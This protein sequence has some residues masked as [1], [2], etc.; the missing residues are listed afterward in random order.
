M[1]FTVTSNLIEGMLVGKTVVGIRE[2]YYTYGKQLNADDIKFLSKQ[3]VEGL[4][5]LESEPKQVITNSL[6]QECLNATRE[7][8][9]DAILRV[10]PK[11]AEEMISSENRLVDIR[12]ERTYD[13]YLQYHCFYTAVYAVMVGVKLGLEKSLIEKLSLCGLLHD[14]GITRVDREI[15]NKTEKLSNEE[16]D[17]IKE[18]TKLGVEI[19]ENDC[20]IST[21]V[22]ETVLHHHENVNGT[23][24]PGGL[25]DNNISILDKILRVADSYDALVAKRPYREPMSNAEAQ[26]YL[27]GGKKIL[28]DE[29][30]VDAFVSVVAPFPTGIE[31]NLSNGESGVVLQQTKDLWKPVVSIERKGIVDLSTSSE[32]T[33]VVINDSLPANMNLQELERAQENRLASK[34]KKK[35]L[36]VDD[37]FVSLVYTKALLENDFDVVISLGGKEAFTKIAVE[38]PDL[39]LLD[40]EMPEMNGVKMV[41]E[42]NN[43]GFY[44]PIIFLTGKSNSE[45][46][47]MCHKCG[48]VDY[49][50]K[51][52][53]AV[54]LKKRIEIALGELIELN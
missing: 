37:V 11:L 32:Y 51:P 53:N 10:A 42:M 26:L 3:G 24:Y 38:K 1:H 25:T 43:M 33:N 27:M 23:G 45:V 52:A 39:I 19:L 34:P 46:V 30:V 13:D 35:I 15:L 16:F 2:G 48:A 12:S 7:M 40:Y 17:C 36:I 14:I 44:V 28:F 4:Y 47:K 20:R 29:K 41:Q 22:K 9:V 31:V 18:H 6:I 5:I 54:Y 50:L 21:L 8:N 49:I